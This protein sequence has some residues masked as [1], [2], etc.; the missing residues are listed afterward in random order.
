MKYVEEYRQP[1]LVR[2][3]SQALHSI[4]KNSWTIMEVCGGQTHSIVKFGLQDLLPPQ[5]RLIHGPGCPVCVTPTH[6]IDHALYISSKPHT[7]VCSYGDMLRV[8]GSYTD[9][10]TMKAKG[11]DIRVLTSPLEAIEIAQKN[12]HKQI[13]LFGVGF[14]TTAPANA[15]AVY[16]AS[17]LGLS[18]FFLLASHV[19]VPPAIEFLLQSPGNAVQGFLAAGHVCT[20]TGY[21][22]YHALANR[23]QTP[24]VVTGFEPVDILQGLYLCIQQL[25]NQEYRVV[26]QY[27]RSVQEYGNLHAQKILDTVFQTIDQK[28]RG[29]GLIPSSGLGLRDAYARYDASIHFPMKT[30]YV[31]QENGCI[32]GLILQGKKRPCEC[33]LFGKLCTPESP[34]GAPMVSTEGACSAYYQYSKRL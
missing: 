26:N 15:M 8:P 4:T 20:V 27:P 17:Q 24:I 14:E 5:I 12:P 22:H 19:L 31:D 33:P 10:L 11:S 9:L 29:I 34:L 25:E 28:W 2:K 21:N 3:L 23:Y 18:N 1:H 16:R 32:S 6:L 13:V 7:I 30:S